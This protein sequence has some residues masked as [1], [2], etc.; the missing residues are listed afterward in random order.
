[1]TQEPILKSQDR[2]EL[3][4]D[5]VRLIAGERLLLAMCRGFLYEVLA[6]LDSSHPLHTKCQSLLEATATSRLQD[7]LQ[8][9]ESESGIDWDRYLTPTEIE[10]IKLG[11]E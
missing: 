9:P 11:L 5:S 2:V 4:Q 1:M 6:E 3:S 10:R 8:I 7:L